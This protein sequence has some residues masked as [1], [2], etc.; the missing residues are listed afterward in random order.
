MGIATGP[1]LA[2]EVHRL[3]DALIGAVRVALPVPGRGS[4][5][6][7]FRALYEVAYRDVELARLAE[8]HHDAH[9]IA[10][11]LGRELRP[12]LYGVWA[13]RGPEPLVA[14][15]FEHGYRVTG[16]VPWCTGVGIVDRALVVA[17]TSDI[18]GGRRELLLDLGAQEGSVVK[19][20]QQ[21][22]SPAF[23]A[24]GTASMRFEG[25]IAAT[26]VLGEPDAYARRSGFWHGAIGVAACWAGGLGGLVDHYTALWQRTDGHSFA[27]LGGAGAWSEA[28]ASLVT[29]AA[30]DIDTNPDDYR[31]AQARA[32]SVRHVVERA[33]M[34]AM[35][36]L[37]VGAGPGPLA[38]DPTTV[39]RTQQLALYI[40]QC[41]GERDLEPLGRS[42]IAVPA[43]AAGDTQLAV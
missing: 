30:F 24:T 43:A 29:K 3:R 11:D 23:A 12:G 40:R 9:A 21:W 37:A 8:A 42:L 25:S 27:R 17:R 33:C 2:A 7:R 15:A 19:T 6:D 26:A 35:E 10:A 38:F 1:D 20:S 4:T 39:T 5:P 14:T 28:A 31:S 22:C 32:R 36:D 16:I 34:F 41:H 18:A 13:A